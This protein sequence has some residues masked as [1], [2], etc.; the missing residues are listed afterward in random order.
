MQHGGEA[1][2]ELGDRARERREQVEVDMVRLGAPVARVAD[3]ELEHVE[4]RIHL[5][6][7]EFLDDGRAGRALGGRPKHHRAHEET[8]VELLRLRRRV[9]HVRE[10]RVGEPAALHLEAIRRQ[11][12][13]N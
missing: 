1:L 3:G 6:G 8:R 9:V 12:G 13:G 11:L 7:H 10:P 5:N 4:S 2:L